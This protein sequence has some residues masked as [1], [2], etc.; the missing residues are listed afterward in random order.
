MMKKVIVILMALVPALTLAGKLENALENRWRGAWVVT[1]VDTYSDCSGVYTNNRVNGR[2]VDSEGRNRFQPGEL[3]KVKRVDAKRSRLDLHLVVVEPML[4]PYEEGPFTLYNETRCFFE[5]EVEIPRKL[6]KTKNVNAVE[7]FLSPILLRFPTEGEAK[8]S[9]V[10]NRRE[11][12]PYP[13]DYDGILAQHAIWKAEQS[14]LAIQAKL[15]RAVNETY[16]LRERMSS[17]PEYLAGFARGVEAARTVNLRSCANLM[18]RK[19]GPSK[20]Y[21]STAYGTVAAV[22]PATK[23]FQDGKTFVYGLEMIRRLP[24][25]FV[26]VP[27]TSASLSDPGR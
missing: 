6:V 2:F 13:D 7:E 18:A 9:R 22:S 23:G 3:A 17:N 1:T 19:L 16:R 11:R 24:D 27:D 4:T 12:D 26:H 20:S 10:Y 25:C 8:R 15:E 14:N 5:L 21:T